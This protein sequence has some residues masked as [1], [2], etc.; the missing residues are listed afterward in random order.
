MS[1]ILDVK[2]D[3][4]PEFHTLPNG[5]EV[6]LRIVAAEMRNSKAGDPMLALRMDAPIDPIA[7]DINHFIMLPNSKDT[8]KQSAQKLNRLKEFKAC[9]KLPATGP[10]AEEDMI[11]ATG[12]AILAEEESEEF[13]KQN[14]VKRFIVGA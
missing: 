8:E 6:E 1:F 14:K 12:W 7:K 10:I 3:D 5:S 11:G 9:F 4:A 2:T 13:G